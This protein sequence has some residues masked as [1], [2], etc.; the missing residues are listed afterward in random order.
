MLNSHPADITLLLRR[1]RQGDG[2]AME[3]LAPIIYDALRQ[4]AR[5]NLRQERDNHTLQPTALLHEA[6]MRLFPDGAPSGLPGYDWK[7][8]AHFLAVASR[9]MRQILV[10][11]A[12]AK[13]A[14]K[15][16]GELMRL[17]MKEFA[18][19][20]PTL[21]ADLL[22]ID[23]A[24]TRLADELPRAAQV[25]E[26][27]YICGFTEEETAEALGISLSTLKRDWRFAKAWLYDQLK[28][29]P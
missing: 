19:S 16:N 17:E 5:S 3:A 23:E 26:M 28:P 10:D 9:Q 20:S 13:R 27:R 29:A 14:A 15:R 25:V 12:R 6:W 1:S 11:H 21:S 22:A 8:R 4:L 18:V 24:L 7:D 2:E